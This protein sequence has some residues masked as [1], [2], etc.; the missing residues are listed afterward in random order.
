M[1]SS[2]S[3]LDSSRRLA[4]TRQ[5]ASCG[6]SRELLGRWAG[7]ADKSEEQQERWSG[8]LEDGECSENV[9]FWKLPTLRDL[10]HATVNVI[11]RFFHKQEI[12]RREQTL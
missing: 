8:V 10:G 5:P 12:L 7:N 11:S 2:Y 4:E 9:F 1:H 6:E 3:R